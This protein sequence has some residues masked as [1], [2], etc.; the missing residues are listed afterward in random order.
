MSTPQQYDVA[1]VGGGHNGLA[2][3]CYLAKAG[4]KVIVLESQPKVGGMSASGYLMPDAPKHL[5]HS[6]ALDLMSLRVHP[7][8]PGE[9]ELE[10][11]G[12]RQVEMSPAYAYLH[13]DGN[14][15]VF[16]RD[17]QKTAAEI[18]R[19]SEKDAAAF[20]R[21]MKV[22]DLF[23]AIAVPM[24]RVDPA[25]KNILAKLRVMRTAFLGRKLRPELMALITS[26]AYGATLEYFEHP[27]TISAM[28]S[29]TGAAG[30]ITA[31][32]SGI[33][34]ALLGF[35][36]KFGVGRV[37][38]GMQ[39]LP[40]AMASRLA[41]LGGKVQTSAVVEEIVAANGRV[42][43]VRLKDG[44]TISAKAVIAS[45]HPKMALDMV[46]KGQVEQRLLT[47]IAMAPANAHGASPLRV[48][49]ALR[50]LVSVDRHEAQ[51]GDGVSLRKCVLLIG[52]ADAVLENFA[53]SARGEVPKLPYMWITAPSAIDPTQAPSGQDVV[54]LYP[55]AMPVFPREGWDAIRERTA[56]QTIAQASLYMN[57]LAEYEIARRIETSADLAKRLNVQNG[58]VTHLDTSALRSNTLRPA[59]GLGG[60][61]LPVAGLYFG[62]AGIHPG[63]GVNGMPGRLAASRVK[64]FLG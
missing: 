29:L 11:H 50:G 48:D 3:A 40:D 19:Y 34:F 2:A 7:I 22:V 23:I 42:K 37:I 62:G 20:L 47:R 31:E 16:W 33:F 46:T 25:R 57:G 15:L 55:P 51:R 5:V 4:K 54:Y 39:A 18:R 63:G 14:S 12:F 45:C 13:P 17:P 38:G 24:M 35:L 1:I 9:L 41:E 58:C 59:Y 6:C 8:V 36:H 61:T 32:G 44:G 21:L 30:P 64:R 60:D 56:A 10:R 28:A 49:L 53:S 26:S 43:G 52:T 27:I